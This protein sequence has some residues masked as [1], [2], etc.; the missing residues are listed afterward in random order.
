MDKDDFF[1][2]LKNLSC[3]N[4]NDLL[5][6][7]KLINHLSLIYSNSQSSNSIPNPFDQ[8]SNLQK[9]KSFSYKKSTSFY[10]SFLID[11]LTSKNKKNKKI[12]LSKTLQKI[13]KSNEE[14]FNRQIN[15]HQNIFN[16]FDKKD[17]FFSN[18]LNFIRNAPLEKYSLSKKIEIVMESFPG[19]KP[20]SNW[21]LSLDELI[22]KL[23]ENDFE[24][25]KIFHQPFDEKIKKNFVLDAIKQIKTFDEK[26]DIENLQKSLMIFIS[27]LIYFGDF[28]ILFKYLDILKTIKNKNILNEIV[29]KKINDEKYN[30]F[31]SAIKNLFN[32]S[33]SNNFSPFPIMRSNSI[34]DLFNISKSI[35]YYSKRNCHSQMERFYT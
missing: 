1:K 15:Y 33:S 29:T 23:N 30:F 24:F 35:L 11:S 14:Y 27:F 22:N 34:I 26:N 5:D 28:I 32:L 10:E 12:F 17:K 3:Y 16:I 4:L 31:K 21:P 6:N 25:E 9:N 20:L 2:I 8:N 13:F 18:K 7:T 19:L